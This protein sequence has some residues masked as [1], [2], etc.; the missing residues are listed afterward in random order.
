MR[1]RKGWVVIACM[2]TVLLAGCQADSTNSSKEVGQMDQAEEKQLKEQAIQYIQKKYNKE[3]EV[4]EVDKGRVTGTI[5]IDGVVKDGEDT[6]ISIIWK[7]N[8]SIDD[9]YVSTLW[10]EELK[11]E[12]TSILNKHFEVRRVQSITYSNGTK[13]SDYTGDVP[14]VFKVL[15]NGGDSDYTL[16]S[17][18]RIYE[19]GGQY[20]TGLRE[21][22]KEIQSMNFNKFLIEIFVADDKLKSAP[23]NIE[24][25]NYTLYRY[26]INIDDIQKVD[27]NNLDLDQYKT[28]IK[29]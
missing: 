15:E 14:S 11:P 13:K 3:F 12:I 27:I 4:I 26:N 20:E 21:L 2:L 6:S 16:E 28:V 17:T 25:S 23:K 1:F 10:T 8:D 24:E 19:N 18:I 5:Y 22:L 7:K 9:T 29:H